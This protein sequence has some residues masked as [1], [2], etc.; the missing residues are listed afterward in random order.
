MKRIIFLI[1]AIVISTTSLVAQKAK[2]HKHRFHH[3]GGTEKITID[4]SAVGSNTTTVVFTDLDTGTEY[5]VNS[6]DGA[7]QTLSLPRKANNWFIMFYMQNN[8][9][10][11]INY[12]LDWEIANE[13]AG[14]TLQPG[15]NRGAGTYDVTVE[16]NQ[17]YTFIRR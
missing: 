12:W 8:E 11:E 5:S 7:I 16:R 10:S 1:V 17:T 15:E 6:N 14:I 2:K 13:G 9:T 3:H 4:F